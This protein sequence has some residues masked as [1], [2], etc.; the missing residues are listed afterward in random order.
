MGHIAAACRDSLRQPSESILSAHS[1]L[2]SNFNLRAPLLVVRFK[3]LRKQS[4]PERFCYTA[5]LRQPLPRFETGAA[6]R[7]QK[8][9]FK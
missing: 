2:P 9:E 8:S 5:Y 7:E 1:S 6:G 3:S 4:S